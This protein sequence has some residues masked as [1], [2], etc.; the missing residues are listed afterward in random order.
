MDACLGLEEK[1]RN[2]HM[3]CGDNSFPV[4]NREKCF[5]FNLFQNMH[6]I[7]SY[8]LSFAAAVSIFS[9][10]TFMFFGLC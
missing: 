2:F 7:I 3:S 8:F 4:D 6:P 5:V 1:Q 9:A 10:E